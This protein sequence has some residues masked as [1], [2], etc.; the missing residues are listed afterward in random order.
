MDKDKLYQ[1]TDDELLLQ[2]KQMKKEKLFYAVFIGFLAG[3][4]IFGLVSWFLNPERK[5]GFLIPMMIPAVFIYRQFKK[6]NKYADLEAVLK[7]RDL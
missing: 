2:K 4:L 1:M 3:V 6:K 7:E 5:V